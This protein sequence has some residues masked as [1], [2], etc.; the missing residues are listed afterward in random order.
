ML[1]EE[2]GVLYT[3][4]QLNFVFKTHYLEEFVEENT[5]GIELGTSV[6]Y[7]MDD[8]NE[9]M[10]LC[11]YLKAQLDVRE[12]LLADIEKKFILDKFTGKQQN[13]KKWLIQFEK[14]WGRYKVTDEKKKIESLGLFLEK[15]GKE[16]YSSNLRKLEISKWSEWS[17]SLLLIY[18]NK[19]WSNVRFAYNYKYI[20]GSLFDYS[21]KTERLLLEIESSMS[22][23]SRINL[24]VMGLLF[25]IQDKLDKEKITN[26]NLLMNR[27]GMYDTSYNKQK[28]ENKMK[29]NSNK[30]T[31]TGKSNA[32]KKYSGVSKPFYEKKTL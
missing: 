11:K 31:V 22:N 29:C 12:I 21:L 2:L 10:K 8:K 7:E 18:M 30:I 19:S 6:N 9:L 3:D 26:T 1:P 32:D 17:I 16:W 13:A 4:T 5:T 23:M 14:E 28:R 25:N 20:N 24:I 15:G 27:I